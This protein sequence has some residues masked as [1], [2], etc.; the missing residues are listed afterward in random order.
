M[1]RKT[2]DLFNSSE[3]PAII[4][5]HHHIISYFINANGNRSKCSICLWVNYILSPNCISVFEWRT[6]NKWGMPGPGDIPTL[7]QL[8]LSLWGNEG[9]ADSV[10]SMSVWHW[11]GWL[12][13]LWNYAGTW[14]PHFKLAL[15]HIPVE[16]WV[17]TKCRICSRCL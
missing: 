7:C 17:N 16:G 4:I 5:L 13:N 12:G 9:C 3:N 10:I 15:C 8:L 11:F 1:W 2:S 6:F 14:V